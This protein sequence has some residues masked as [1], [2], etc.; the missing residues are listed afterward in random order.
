[1]LGYCSF[2]LMVDGVSCAGS[3]DDRSVVFM[4]DR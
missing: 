3:Y 2:P 4:F 1:M